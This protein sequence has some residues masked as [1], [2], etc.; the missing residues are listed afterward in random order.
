MRRLSSLY[1]LVV[2]D[3]AVFRNFLNVLSSPFQSNRLLK[4]SEKLAINIDANNGGMI[5]TADNT[6]MPMM[7]AITVSNALARGFTNENADATMSH[8]SLS[9][10][11]RRYN[12][13][14]QLC[15]RLYCSSRN[16]TTN[17]GHCKI[18]IR[19]NAPLITSNIRNI[20]KIGQYTNP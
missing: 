19:V 20:T 18:P 8:F 5:L 1:T 17:R 6:M 16:S 15:P 7:D 14:T 2:L 13:L 10:M 3:F 11:N 9:V 12:K 4:Y